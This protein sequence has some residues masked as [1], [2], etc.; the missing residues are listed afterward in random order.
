MLMMRLNLKLLAIWVVFSFLLISIRAPEESIN[1]KIVFVSSRDGNEEIYAMNADGTDVRQLTDNP[2]SDHSPVWSPDGTKIAFVS[3]REWNNDIYVMNADGTNPVQLTDSFAEDLNPSWSP[4]GARI[5]FNSD[6]DGLP[7][8]YVMDADGSHVVRVTN[9]RDWNAAPVWSPDGKHIAYSSTQI[10]EILTTGDMSSKIRVVDINGGTTKELSGKDDSFPAWSPDGER[11]AFSSFRDGNLEIYVMDADGTAQKR[12]TDHP[13]KD[14]F[15][16]WSPDGERI[17]F[18][19]DRDGNSEICIM[20]ADGKNIVRIT[21]DPS[22][23][24]DPDWHSQDVSPPSR[25]PVTTP[26][27]AEPVTSPDLGVPSVQVGIPP[28][29]IQSGISLVK[30]SYELRGSHGTHWEYWITRHD[31]GEYYVDK[32]SGRGILSSSPKSGEKVDKQLIQKLAESFTDFYSTDEILRFEGTRLDGSVNFEVLVKLD[33]GETLSMNTPPDYSGYCLIPWSIEYKD[34]KYLQS[35]G[36]ISE[37]VLHLLNELGDD[38]E[39]QVLYDKEIRW[40]CYPAV[41]HFES[42]DEELSNDFP[43]STPV[44]TL[45]EKLGDMYVLWKADIADIMY[46]S[47]YT[48]NKIYIVTKGHIMAIDVETHQTVLDVGIEDYEEREGT[49]LVHEGMVYAAVPPCVY[50][51]TAQTGDIVWKYTFPHSGSLH[52]IPVNEKLIIWEE[53]KWDEG[54]IS[55]LDAKSGDIV[56]EIPEDL[57]FLGVAGGTILYKVEK[58]GRDREYIYVLADSNA[59]EKIWEKNSS[60]FVYWDFDIV[61]WSYYDGV[62]YTDKEDEGILI[63]LDTETMEE[64]VLYSHEKF[65]SEHN[66]GELV[67]YCQAFEE[68]ILLSLIELGEAKGRMTRWNTRIVFLDR[69]GEELWDYHYDEKSVGSLYCLSGLFYWR[70]VY[71]PVERAEIINDTLFLVRQNGFVE[72]FNARNGGK[73]WESEVRDSVQNLFVR[74]KRL[75]MAAKDCTI[76]CLDMENGEIIWELKACD[77]H[78]TVDIKVDS[79]F[80]WHSVSCMCEHLIDAVEIGNEMLV[81]T[82]EDGLSAVSLIVD[83]QMEEKLKNQEEMEEEREDE[84]G[85][86]LGTVFLVLLV[87]AGGFKK[88][89]NN[90]P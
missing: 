19:S 28:N 37:A 62:L 9:D 66:P 13:R 38:E 18:S 58:G 26:Q 55:C 70:F 56:W 75:Y 45:T 78:C 17:V 22:S 52:V 48:E 64:R 82:T 67:Q 3:D 8:I 43:H 30:I 24:D 32:S 20:G 89:I 61:N 46:P 85:F 5:A 47:A 77:N 53:T 83:V 23:D 21:E 36:K 84:G 42:C 31:D 60:S 88:L 80:P 51:L 71:N 54:I 81:V 25:E 34:K 76:Y 63:A 4:D 57:H 29:S 65:K 1:G 33:N 10:S 68:G 12:L 73:M 11:I 49:I 41:L 74:E 87:I 44:V 90:S 40:G 50:G 39:L 15:P 72:A 16:A 35:N 86:C 27:P 59:G 7:Q 79:L 69:T 2:A 14:C 6:R